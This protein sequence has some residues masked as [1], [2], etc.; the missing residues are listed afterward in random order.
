MPPIEE[1]KGDKVETYQDILD[2]SLV[3]QENYFDFA[4]ASLLELEQ[5][6]I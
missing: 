1:T 6:K 4:L 5:P 3:Y 2:V